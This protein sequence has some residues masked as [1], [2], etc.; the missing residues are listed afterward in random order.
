[1][2]LM[3]MK[4]TLI[5]LKTQ[6][7]HGVSYIIASKVRLTVVTLSVC[8]IGISIIVFT[9]FALRPSQADV[10]PALIIQQSYDG[11]LAVKTIDQKRFQ[12]IIQN[13]WDK[14]LKEG[15]S[16]IVNFPH[17]PSLIALQYTPPAAP[18]PIPLVLY[19]NKPV[20]LRT[21]KSIELPQSQTSRVS[22]SAQ[23]YQ[24]VVV[25]EFTDEVKELELERVLAQAFSDMVKTPW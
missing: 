18:E 6:V 5:S 13:L 23:N 8:I 3:N 24:L 22:L 15:S 11:A 14:A 21:K 1:M 12:A 20:L 16:H 2:A 4:N 19:R 17:D 7:T 10:P 9:F 25:F